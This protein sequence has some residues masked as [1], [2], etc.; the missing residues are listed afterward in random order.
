MDN[1]RYIFVKQNSPEINPWY[2]KTE[3]KCINNSSL[4]TE[5]GNKFKIYL[6]NC[7]RNSGSSSDMWRS[8]LG[9]SGVQVWHASVHELQKKEQTPH[10]HLA[11]LPD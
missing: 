1:Y 5:S 2:E 7:V 3:N 6:N 11:V 8:S 4:V 10:L 9:T